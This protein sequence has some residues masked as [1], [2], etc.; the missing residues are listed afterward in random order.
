[1]IES[2]VVEEIQD[3]VQSRAPFV[4]D[5]HDCCQE[6]LNSIM[7]SYEYESELTE[8]L[9]DHEKPLHLVEN[10]EAACDAFD[11]TQTGQRLRHEWLDTHR[12]AGCLDLEAYEAFWSSLLYGPPCDDYEDGSKVLVH[13]STTADLVK[14]GLMQY[15]AI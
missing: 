6:A 5:S 9:A 12:H 4:F 10:A 15:F 11:R 14:L 8:F 1:M 2:Y 3:I 7:D 13:F